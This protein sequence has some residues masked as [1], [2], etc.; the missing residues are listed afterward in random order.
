MKKSVF[1]PFLWMAVFCMLSVAIIPHHHHLD[2]RICIQLPTP[3]Q[4]GQD[5]DTTHQTDCNTDCL[6]RFIAYRVSVGNPDLQLNLFTAL[7]AKNVSFDF[8]L[9]DSGHI[10]SST[11]R[12]IIYISDY[13]GV[14]SELRAPPCWV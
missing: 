3:L 8:S 13:K 10:F 14:S 11:F 6:T 2:G 12:N 1:L 9:K 7:P 5:R 4:A